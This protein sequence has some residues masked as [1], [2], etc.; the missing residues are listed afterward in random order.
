[1]SGRRS[2]KPEVRLDPSQYHLRKPRSSSTGKRRH[3]GQFSGKADYRS[4]CEIDLNVEA[5]SLRDRSAFSWFRPAPHAR[6]SSAYRSL[7]NWS[8]DGLPT[9]TGDDRPAGQS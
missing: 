7:G 8:G 3:D 2:R 1:V 9:A 5:A 6:V 4:P